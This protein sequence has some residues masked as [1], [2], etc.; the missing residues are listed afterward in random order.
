MPSE[1]LDKEIN[2]SF[3]DLSADAQDLITVIASSAMEGIKF[4]IESIKDFAKENESLQPELPF[5]IN[6][7]KR[8]RV[9]LTDIG[10]S[11]AR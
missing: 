1:N 2:P 10:V 11:Y 3:Y 9:P 4:D 8:L 5:I 6:E 7:L